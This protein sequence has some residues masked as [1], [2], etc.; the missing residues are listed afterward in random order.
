MICL[1]VALFLL[2]PA[3]EV[4]AATV[5]LP[6]S[7]GA[8]GTS[9]TAYAAGWIEGDAVPSEPINTRYVMPISVN[10]KSSSL[11]PEP[12]TESG[13]ESANSN[14]V[15]ALPQNPSLTAPSVYG[16]SGNAQI[17]LAWNSVPNA[18]SYNIKRSLTSGGPYAIIVNLPATSY[19]YTDNSVTNGITYYYIVTA[20]NSNGESADSNVVS[21]TPED[22]ILSTPQI[23]WTSFGDSVVNNYWNTIPGSTGYNLKRSTSPGGPYTTVTTTTY[24]SYS[25]TSVTNGITY[26]YVVSA[27]KSSGGESG[28]S[29][30]ISVTPRIPVPPPVAPTNLT[31]EVSNGHVILNWNASNNAAAY[32]VRRSVYAG[33]PHMLLASTVTGTTYTDASAAAGVTYY[34][35][36]SAIGAGGESNPSNEAS[37]TIPNQPNLDIA[38][39]ET[40]V[41]VGD[42]IKA[43]VVLKN[44]NNIYAE[45]FSVHYDNNRFEY[46]GI[47]EVSGYKIYNTPIDQNGTIRF[48]IASQGQ[49]YGI[50]GET[51]ILKLKLRAKAAGTG[52]IDAFKCRIANTEREFDLD[53]N[54]CLED[55]V[56]IGDVQDVNKSGDYTLLDLA[57][58]AYYYGKHASNAD[59]V[60]YNVNQA[61]DEFV[62][63]EDLVYIVNKILANS[64]YTPNH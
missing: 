46:L 25:D 14:E 31:G 17:T 24:T 11:S 22:P 62:T 49:A 15:S 44:V 32:N 1:M 26:Y 60:K 40:K 5:S 64:N 54:S 59:P 42:E 27:L 53:E 28:Y 43:N 52:K 20:V 45:D 36:V 29:R 61:G 41:A 10:L 51:I 23:Q 39:A 2:I 38:I 63:N 8:D 13:L 58:D 18:D 4:S 47:E 50:N 56:L 34:Y 21:V 6:L 57:I 37:V 9:V 7:D 3:L 12:P 16:I 30:E 55:T 33:G 35:V 19:S 48:I